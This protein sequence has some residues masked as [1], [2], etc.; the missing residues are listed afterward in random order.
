MLYILKVAGVGS[1]V[2]G[3]AEV[4]EVAFCDLFST[5][6]NKSSFN[7][8]PSLPLPWTSRRSICVEGSVLGQAGSLVTKH[9]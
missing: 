3:V 9:L 6:C 7:I 1:G 4:C 8:L 2:G 5:Y